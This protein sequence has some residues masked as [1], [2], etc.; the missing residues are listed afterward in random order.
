MKTY[1]IL[2]ITVLLI[3]AEGVFLSSSA[4]W[5]PYTIE[6]NLTN[7]TILDIGDLDGDG[8]KDLAI[9]DWRMGA[10]FWYENDFPTWTQYRIATLSGAVGCAIADIDGDDTLDVV[11]AGFSATDVVW[12]E[13]NLPEWTPHIIDSNIDGEDLKVGDMDGDSDLDVVIT[14]TASGQV[15]WYENINLT[16]DEHIIDNNLVTAYTLELVDINGD[17]TLDVVATGKSINTIVCYEN[18]H[19]TW[20]KYPIDEDLPGVWALNTGD[21]DG[22][23][24]QDV[25]SAGPGVNS[26][27]W[28]KNDHPTWTK[29]PI[30]ENLPG[31]GSVYI[32]DMDNDDTLDVLTTGSGQ[33]LWYENNLP[34][35][36]EH[37]IDDDSPAGGSIANDFDNDGNVDVLAIS[38]N[39]IVYYDNK[40]AVARVKSMQCFPKFIPTQDDT[41]VINARLYNPDS[42]PATVQAFISSEQYAFTD[43]IP[44]YDDGQHS[45]SLPSDN[46]WGNSKWFSGLPED[47]YAIEVH[48]TDIVEDYT[49]NLPPSRS[50]TTIGPVK[51]VESFDHRRI[52]TAITRFAFKIRLKNDDQVTT[53]KDIWARVKLL[54]EDSCFTM[55]DNRYTYGDIEPGEA[56]DGNLEYAG[57]VDTSCLKGESLLENFIVEIESNGTVFWTDTFEVDIIATDITDEESTLPKKFA[58]GQNYPN[59]FNPT[60]IINYELPTTITVDLSI[61]NLL[62]QRVATLVDERQQAG[63]QQVE[64][65]ASGFASGVYYYRIEAGEF[66][67]VRK[68]MLLR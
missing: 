17:D 40:P 55:Y 64:W 59:P 53:A 66:V 57:R 54:S 27:V 10:V 52:E 22:N 34:T 5:I 39:S 68:M 31:V 12:Y 35:W 56:V 38:N 21:L 8:D 4:Q 43:S 61:Y 11:A 36:N 51:V 44:L 9:S 37:V 2:T 67:D 1:L 48:S 14:A 26:I 46:I 13:N 63:S 19:P 6:D 32:A 41:L 45:D 18:D 23:G 20:T 7:A 25:V 65:N 29:Y 16:W 28:Y 47:I 58:L 50:F 62:G 30:D 24:T 42:H 3:I 15:V 60:T 33:V 49:Y